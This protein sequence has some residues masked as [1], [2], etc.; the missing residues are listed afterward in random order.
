M[1][2][3]PPLWSHSATDLAAGFAQGDFTP[4]DVLDSVIERIATVNPRINALITSDLAGARAT[5]ED[6]ALRWRSRTPLSAL[7]G[8]PLTVKDNIPVAGMRATWGSSLFEHYVPMRDELPVARLRAAGAII[9]GKTNCP[10]FTVQGHTSNAIFG[11]TRNPYDLEMTP[12]GS[13]GGAVAA[14]SAGICPIAIATDGGGSIRRPASYTGLFGLKPS[15]GRVA[16]AD[17]FATILHDCEVIGPIARTMEDIRLV[18]RIIGQPHSRDPL[19]TSVADE[20]FPTNSL[21]P[22]R[23]LFIPQFGES[24]VDP[25]IARQVAAAADTLASLGHHVERG[26]VPF[27]IDALGQAWSVI[28]Q[29]GLNWLLERQTGWEARVG[30]DIQ[31]M[32]EAGGQ[33]HAAQYYQS[34][35]QF[36]DLK[37]RLAE[38]FERYDLIMTPSAAA[39]PWPVTQSFPTVI[40][41]RPVGP[42]GHAIFTAFANM[43]GCAALNLPAS[44]SPEGMPIG[45]QLVGPIG[46]DALLCDIGT[47]YET[48]RTEPKV[49]PAL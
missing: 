29:T 42:R 33:L 32:V 48:H 16:R 10:E 41:A 36:A 24:P 14:V 9:V 19:S 11:T 31:S 37:Y 13:S 7:D 49:W 26:A 20:H 47:Q 6:S 46:A 21:R 40:D 25:V 34:L 3:Q 35:T 12:G 5:A 4:V 18:M 22:C 2:N 8:V 38:V 15:R 17:G 43:S 30:G 1:S 44:A 27:D 39:M 45:F 28:S 23:I